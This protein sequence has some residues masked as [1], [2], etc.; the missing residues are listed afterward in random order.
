M[1]F[2]LRTACAFLICL[3]PLQLFA[4][5]LTGKVACVIDG[6]TVEVLD[7]RHIAHRIRLTGIDARRLGRTSGTRPNSG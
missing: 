2:V 4:N 7:Q 5:T 1:Y 6:D 3:L